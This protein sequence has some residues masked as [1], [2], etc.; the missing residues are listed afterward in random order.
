[1]GDT[2]LGRVLAQSVTNTTPDSCKECTVKCEDQW[3]L[4]QLQTVNLLCDDHKIIEDAMRRAK[5][6][7]GNYAKLYLSDEGTDKA[8]A[9]LLA[10]FSRFCSQTGSGW[11]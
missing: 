4:V 5:R 1:M 3:S 11:H 9:L 2:L 8:G 6:T 10:R 7:A